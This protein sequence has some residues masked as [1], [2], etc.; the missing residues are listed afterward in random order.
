MRISRTTRQP[1]AL[2]RRTCLW[3]PGR[4]CSNHRQEVRFQVW[5]LP[6]RGDD[7]ESKLNKVGDLATLLGLD[8][9]QTQ[10][11]GPSETDRPCPYAFASRTC[12]QSIPNAFGAHCLLRRVDNVRKRQSPWKP[13]AGD[14]RDVRVQD[15]RASEGA[16]C[17]DVENAQHARQTRV[18]ICSMK[19]PAFV[20]CA[21]KVRVSNLMFEDSGNGVQRARIDL[22]TV[23]CSP[24]LMRINV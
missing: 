13:T 4:R 15:G 20:G 1:A 14:L 2:L 17:N 3:N 7:Q 11:L 8:V 22:P 16:G 24:L 23:R 19:Q 6:N 18:G 9:V 21:R 10:G 12:S 5:Y